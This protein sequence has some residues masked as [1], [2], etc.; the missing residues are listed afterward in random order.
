VKTPPDR[1]SCKFQEREHERCK[2][3]LHRTPD[4]ADHFSMCDLGAQPESGQ[5]GHD[6]ICGRANEYWQKQLNSPD[7]GASNQAFV[8]INAR[9][10]PQLIDRMFHDTHDS[11]LRVSLVNVLNGLPGVQIDF[12]PADL[13]RVSAVVCVGD[14][15]PAARDAVPDLIKALKGYDPVVYNPAISALG[16]IHSDPDTVIPLLIT[17]LDNS[18]LSNEAAFA[19][20]GYGGLANAAVPKIIPMLKFGDDAQ[21]AARYAL[22]KIDPEAAAEAGV[23]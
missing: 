19:L 10:I 5:H 4:Y 12:M 23:K 2:T 11:K 9:I 1:G 20:A 7:A 8:T 21:E 22:L 14:F 15:G 3:H 17:C 6:G 16:K 18:G 13:R